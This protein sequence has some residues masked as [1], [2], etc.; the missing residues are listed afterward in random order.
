[1]NL[2]EV[3]EGDLLPPLASGDPTIRH[4]ERRPALPGYALHYRLQQESQPSE[5]QEEG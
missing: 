2:T 3:R 5:Q 4:K 1:M